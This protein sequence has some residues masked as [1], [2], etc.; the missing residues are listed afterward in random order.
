MMV[1]V[2]LFILLVDKTSYFLWM[3]F[4]LFIDHHLDLGLVR[5]SRGKETSSD[6]IRLIWRENLPR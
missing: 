2:S 4:R 1:V 5:R 6:Q 3:A